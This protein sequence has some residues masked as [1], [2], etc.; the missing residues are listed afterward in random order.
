MVGLLKRRNLL[1]LSFIGPDEDIF[2]F[3]GIF[4]LVTYIK[5]CIPDSFYLWG[6]IL[7]CDHLICL[8][9]IFSISVSLP[10]LKITIPTAIRVRIIP[11]HALGTSWW[12]WVGEIVMEIRIIS[13][14]YMFGII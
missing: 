8:T 6:I 9:I 5:K 13:I 4:H 12:R 2:I 11:V 14:I 1:I 10:V 7:A 3:V